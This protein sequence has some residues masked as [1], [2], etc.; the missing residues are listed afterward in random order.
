MKNEPTRWVAA[1]DGAQIVAVQHGC[2]AS[3]GPVNCFL[4]EHN[5]WQCPNCMAT[6]GAA[7]PLQG[8]AETPVPTQTAQES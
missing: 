8:W 3:D 7:V 2:G 4:D 1:L 5:N 6:Y